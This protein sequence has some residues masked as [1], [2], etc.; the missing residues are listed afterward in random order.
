MLGNRQKPHWGEGAV[1]L[2]RG[3]PFI[4]LSRLQTFFGSFHIAIAFPVND[5]SA[6]PCIPPSQL[7]LYL[8]SVLGKILRRI[9]RWL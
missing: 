8:H 4:H 2:F 5:F 1:D 7:P 6:L 9:G 3:I